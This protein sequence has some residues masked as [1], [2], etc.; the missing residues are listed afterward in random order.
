MC[1]IKTID[2]EKKELRREISKKRKE[3]INDSR[4]SIFDSAICHKIINSSLYKDAEILLVYIPAPMENNIFPVIRK[5]WEDGK[6]VLSPKCIPETREMV[7]YRINSM[8]EIVPSEVY[9]SIKEPSEKCRKWTAERFDK[10]DTLCIVPAM[11]FDSEGYRLGFGGGYYDRFLAKLENAV[12]I[13]CCYDYLM[14]GKVP[15]D[16]YDQKV[17]WVMT[18]KKL[19]EVEH[20]K[21]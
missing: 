12:T 20:G 4:K 10:R 8:S 2:E 1:K 6:P 19:L 13:G 14:C 15:T 17:D 16:S 7:F 11:T 18:E 21:K 9:R 5:A 3:F